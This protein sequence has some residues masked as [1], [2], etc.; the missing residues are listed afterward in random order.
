M[1]ALEHHDSADWRRALLFSHLESKN[2]HGCDNATHA[3]DEERFFIFGVRILFWKNATEIIMENPVLGVGTSSFRAAFES[4]LDD[5]IGWRRDEST[6]DPHNQYLLITSEFGLIGLGIF[7]L[8]LGSLIFPSR[9]GVFETLALVL[10][11]SYAVNGLANGH[12]G[13]FT[14]GRLIWIFAG[15]MLAGSRFSIEAR[16]LSR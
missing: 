2:Q 5:E 14:E 15:A 12:F 16:R 9:I 10:V 3:F 7:I 8:L 11:L 1:V 4:K 6:D 13:G